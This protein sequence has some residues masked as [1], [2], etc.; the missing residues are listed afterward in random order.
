VAG[1]DGRVCSSAKFADLPA[2]GPLRGRLALAC[3]A[4]SL[5]GFDKQPAPWI[6]P[7]LFIEPTPS[8]AERLV[9]LGSAFG[10]LTET[11]GQS[12][13]VAFVHLKGSSIGRWFAGSTIPGEPP[14]R[15][16]HLTGGLTSSSGFRSR[17]KL[18]AA[19]DEGR[20]VGSEGLSSRPLLTCV[21]CDHIVFAQRC[22]S[23]CA[24]IFGLGP[25]PRSTGVFCAAGHS[26]GRTHRSPR[27]PTLA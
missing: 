8:G 9:L 10:G 6:R 21:R 20:T 2:C 22:F 11:N 3:P 26:G 17:R 19:V 15:G 1:S 7:S 24:N 27:A 4:S 13:I 12:R 16:K 14:S 18:V 23:Q 25:D 5:S